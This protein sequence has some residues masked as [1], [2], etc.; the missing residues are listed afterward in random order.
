FHVTGVQTCALPIC[1]QQE[2]ERVAFSRL[3]QEGVAY[4]TSP[5]TG[6]RHVA[7]PGR[8]YALVNYMI[9]GT[10]AEI[11]K[12]KLLELAAAGLDEYMILPVHDEII[13][14]V[15]RDVQ[16]SVVETIRDIMN[17]DTIISVPITAGV[18]S[19][20]RWGEKVDIFG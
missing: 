9:Q 14:D 8:E 18:A 17:D 15:P 19:G 5:L 3:A 20:E 1:F 12:T 2:V 11:F 16:D 7:D 13:L 10:A 6:R 4:V